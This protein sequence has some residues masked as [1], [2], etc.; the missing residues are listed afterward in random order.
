[1][2]GRLGPIWRAS[3]VLVV[4]LLA[5][6]LPQVLSAQMDRPPK[7]ST[8]GKASPPLTVS[9]PGQGPV[10][11]T[12]DRIEYLRGTAVYEAHGSVVVVQG[13][14]RLTADEVTLLTLSG[15]LIATGH[16]HLQD[17]SSDLEAERLELDVNINAGV[18][19]H[20]QLFIKE[21]NTLITG[22]L[23]QRFS[24]EHFRAKEGSFTNCDAKGGHIPAWR[25]TFKDLDVD[26]G[27]HLFGKNIWFCVHD[28]PVF[29]IPLMYYPLGTRRKTG[30][31]VPTAG[32]N[33]VFGVTYQQGFF[34]AINPSQDLLVTPTLF[35]RRGFG[36]SLRY[37]YILDRRSRGQW[38]VS[39][40]R[41]TVQ[42]RFR[43]TLTGSHV[44]QVTPDLSI[45]ANA[46]LLTD[47]TVFSN[48][49]T[50]GVLR[51]LP[52]TESNF[53]V[54]QRFTTGNLY[55]LGD[56]L[57]P[58][59]IGGLDT[60][61]RLPV[62]GYQTANVAPFRGPLLFNMETTA[63]NFGRQRGFDLSRVDFVPGL[64]T[65]MWNL[66]HLIGITPRFKFRETYYTRGITSRQ[67]QDRATFW[68][69]ISATSRL[70]RQFALDDGGSF[71]HSI[72]PQ[73]IYEYVPP[74]DQSQIIKVD[75]VDNLPK[76]NLA[77]YMLRTR[78]LHANSQGGTSNWLNLIIAQSYHAGGVQTVARNFPAAPL[79]GTL[80][81]PLQ[82]A[83]TPIKGRKFSD[84]WTRAVIGNTVGSGPGVIPLSLTVDSFFDP[85]RGEFSQVNTDLLYQQDSLWYLSIGERHTRPGSR[86]QRGD[87]WNP[88]SFGDVFAPTPELTFL[89]TSG[90]IRLPYGWTVGART[91]YDVKTR[92]SP[93]TD[94]VALYQ[95][96][97][98]CW[99]LGLFFIQLPDRQQFS[100]TVT[101]TGVGSTQSFGSQILRMLLSP[102]LQGERG[103]PWAPL[104]AGGYQ[105]PQSSPS[106]ILAQ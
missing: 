99:S 94:Y 79:F 23:L 106:G 2:A 88:L 98:R 39:F 60:F 61:Q 93:E 49:S 45:R 64:S 91:Y 68:T 26:N 38:L 30:F 13:S 44:Q 51:A 59:Q 102:I 72:E 85:H 46:N 71:F 100:F 10:E 62:L 103:L 89:T 70:T 41:D 82:Y 28:V 16:V 76:K 75:A 35:S 24:E 84:I 104:A 6:F 69:G 5:I 52:S 48:L 92:I 36:G 29:P 11:I 86:V 19:T 101:L 17:P 56:F 74:T 7:H 31:L 83:S 33:T 55:F 80:T 43:G 73:V 50:S 96:P 57:Q 15:T 95:N 18:V 1:M 54:N 97:C 42:D 37:R 12:A 67:S 3:F 66:G 87:I 22:R 9:S 78:L 58:V 65:H 81:Q 40:L 47:R 27:D 8:R 34:W 32:V 20:G 105:S 63:T 4:P 90:A 77:T 25:F 53:L 21:S 14:L